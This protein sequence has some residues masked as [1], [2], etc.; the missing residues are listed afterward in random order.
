MKIKHLLKTFCLSV[1]LIF[2]ASAMW[3]AEVTK[4]Y[5]FTA[6]NWTATCATAGEGETTNWTSGKNGAG[7]SNNGVQVTTASTGANA[8]SPVSFSKISK[9]V[10]TYNT[11]ASKGNGTIDINIGENEV[12]SNTAKYTATEVPDG[13]NGT[14][15]NFTTQFD[16]T[17]PQT[18]SVTI[19]V[20]TTTNSIYVCSIAITYEGEADTEAPSFSAGYPTI[21]NVK[22]TS[23]DLLAKINEAGKVYY[24]VVIDGADAPSV[25]DIIAD[26]NY[27][28]CS[29]NT[30][31]TVTI[32]ELTKATA[33]DIYVVTKDNSDNKQA[34]ATKLDVTT[35]SREISAV[36]ADAK[37]YTGSDVTI[38]W[39]TENIDAS[40]AVKIELYNGST[41]S[42]TL[43][44]STAN[45]GSETVTIDANAAY[46]TNYKVRVSLADNA[47]L[48]AESNAITIVPD[49][50]INKL[51]TDTAANGESNYKGKV[52]RVKGLV[53][54][55][56]PQS[57][58]AYRNFT[59]QNGSG[60]FNAAYAFYCEKDGETYVA[61]GDSVYVEGLVVYYGKLLEIGNSNSHSSATIIN[62]DNDL[63]VPTNVSLKDAMSNAYMSKIVKINELT[64]DGTYLRSATDDAIRVNYNLV[65][66]TLGFVSGRKYDVV[67]GIG[68]N[69]ASGKV[70]YQLLPRSLN[71][72]EAV[73]YTGKDSTYVIDDIYLYSN[74]TTLSV[75]TINGTDAIKQADDTSFVT[76]DAIYM[77]ATSAHKGIVATANDEKATVSV[78]V[79]G[80][81]VATADLSEK[82]LAADDVVTITVTAEDGTEVSYN[83]PLKN[84]NRTFTFTA[85]SKNEFSTGEKIDLAWTQTNVGNIDIYFEAD[86][87]SVKLN[88]DAIADS[89]LSFSYVVPNSV[90]GAGHIKA[91]TTSDNYEIANIAV[92]ISDT[93]IPVATVTPEYGSTSVKIAGNLFLKFDEPVKVAEGAKIKVGSLEFSLVQDGDSLVKAYYEGLAYS[94]IYNVTLPTGAITDIAGNNPNLGTWAFNT[95]AEPVPELFFSEY[96]TGSSNNKY[97]EIFNPI[98]DIVDLSNYFIKVGTYSNSGSFSTTTMSLIGTLAPDEVYVLANKSAADNIKAAADTIPNNYIV[99]FNG[100][101]ALLLYKAV[102]GDTTL[103]DVIGTYNTD[104]GTAWTVAGVENATTKHTLIR[105]PDIICGSDDW[106]EIAGTDSLDSQWIVLECDDITNLGVH[107][108]GRRAKVLAFN[109]NEA[110]SEATINHDAKTI[111]IEVV[112]G[113]NLATLAPQIT[114]SRGATATINGAAILQTVDF[115]NPVE[116]VVTSEDSATINTYTITVTAAVLPSTAAEIRTFAFA[117]VEAESIKIDSTSVSINATMT[118]GTDITALTPKFTISAAASV[119][120]TTMVYIDSINTYTYSE[121]INFTNPLKIKVTAQDTA[122][123]KEWTINVDVIQPKTLSIYDIQYSAKDTSLYINQFVSTTGVVT[124]IVANGNG[125]ELYMQDSPKAW[126]GILVYDETGIAKNVKRGDRVKVVGTVTEY[127]TIT[128]IKIID[129]EI[130]SSGNSIEP[131]QLT[132]EDA[133]TENYESV[134]VTISNMKCIDGSGNTYTAA[135]DNDSLKIYN[136][137]KFDG[138]ELT[139][140]SVYNVTGI[141]YYYSSTKSYEIIPRDTNDIVKCSPI[142][143]IDPTDPTGPNDAVSESAANAVNVYAFNRTIVVENATADVAV[144]DISGRMVAKRTA[145]SSHIEVQL[146]ESGLYIVKVGTESQKVVLQ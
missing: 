9:I 35:E 14:N 90:N 13:E 17:T 87:N 93:Q 58:N 40:T 69:N 132:I 126:N 18:G 84:D 106:G 19:T 92:T 65:S 21:T 136:K 115:T 125:Y 29:A 78:K 61:L 91:I 50:T 130:L 141:M 47:N 83:I 45:D 8:T 81:D 88:T 42:A 3:A 16:Y 25:D 57:S 6:K 7:F 133:A 105:K 10:V 144:F 116:L 99:T 68:Y 11:N 112:Y 44:N 60:V 20:N 137:Y 27:I 43:A 59:L 111:E 30:E 38:T 86:G 66:G 104:P 24:K 48:Y 100:D 142:I 114:L 143:V 146:S 124:S 4:T 15:A 75:L 85:L 110:E 39:T 113:T 36:T 108:V 70:G 134:L 2:S 95:K 121:P 94:K 28:T 145:N 101:D 63:P 138:F 53:T 117:E 34:D 129:I 128:E 139:N 107:G 1:V 103:I 127:Y 23:V 46:G 82:T 89:V 98:D 72:G 67:G 49:I 76:V 119:S 52:V 22:A 26:D 73:T 77:L 79:N 62:H 55:I 122:V 37:F 109:L 12:K 74:D 31:T 120:S 135:V 80:A 64:Y 118:Y 33:Y 51:V 131:V 102:N 41:L 54:G 97:L 32:T 71:A 5:V 140:D 96:S 123:V 56:K